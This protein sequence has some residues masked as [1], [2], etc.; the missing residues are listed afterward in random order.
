MLD[1]GAA[2]DRG[3]SRAM[4]QRTASSGFSMIELLVVIAIIA[5]LAGAVIAGGAGRARLRGGFSVGQPASARDR[6]E[7]PRHARPGAGPALG[8]PPRARANRAG[9]GPARDAT[10]ATAAGQTARSIKVAV[11]L[12]PSEPRRDGG[13]RDQ[14]RRQRRCRFNPSGRVKNGAFGA[15][16]RDFS[17]GLSNT[18]AVAEWVRGNGDPQVRDPKRA[19]FAT[20]IGLVDTTDLGPFGSACHGLD[21]LQAKLETLGKGDRL[22][23]RRLRLLAVQPHP[24]DQRPHLHQRRP[25]RASA[26]TAGTRHPAAPT[27]CSS[28]DMSPS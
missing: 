10:T 18:A 26:W 24:R 27:S 17:D 23:P 15:S 12:C 2:V 4:R 25:R 8:V 20:T 3:R 9:R 28:T 19:V 6:P 5:V 14:L 1:R 7:P 16:V 13:G 11:F 22:D 21:P